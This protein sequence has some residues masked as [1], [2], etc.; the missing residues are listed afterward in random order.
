MKVNAHLRSD[1]GFESAEAKVL[2]VETEIIS[3]AITWTSSTTLIDA[4]LTLDKYPRDNLVIFKVYI[5]GHYVEP[6]KGAPR[7]IKADK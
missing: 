1:F 4:T 3:N 2:S 6:A 5:D 7:R